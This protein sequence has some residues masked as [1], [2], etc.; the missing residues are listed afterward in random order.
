MPDM[1]PAVSIIVPTYN[2]ADLLDETLASL[3]SQRYD[4]IEV[5]VVDDG[6]TDVT[7]QLLSGYS[8]ERIRVIS[9]EN[10]GEIA[11]TM[12]GWAKVRGKYVAVVSSDDPMMAHWLDELVRALD[13]NPQAVVAYPDWAIVNE[14]GETLEIIRTPDYSQSEM[15]RKFRAI[16]GPGALLRKSAADKI[17]KLRREQYRYCSDLD[18][19]LRLSFQGDFVRVPKVLATWRSHPESLTVSV[20]TQARAQE[21]IVLAYE[22]FD[23]I[24]SQQAF[25]HVRNEAMIAAYST[26]AWVVAEKDADAAARFR[27]QGKAFEF[28]T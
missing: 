23:K 1:S 12:A 22:F 5:I 20:R 21:I 25:R 13:R 10:Q 3:L 28:G 14:H 9:Q 11:A 16:P 18:M 19:W 2:R 26:A 8:D 17:G 15:I 6:S 4:N 27:Q 24:D 7:P